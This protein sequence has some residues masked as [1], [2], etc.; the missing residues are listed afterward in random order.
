MLIRRTAIWLLTLG[1]LVSTAGRAVAQP[2]H[3]GVYYPTPTP[4]W[5]NGSAPFAEDG[6][7][8]GHPMIEPFKPVGFEPRFDWFAPA[9]TSSYGRGQKG[10]IGIFLSYERLYWSFA[11]PEKAFIGS[12][13]ASLDPFFDNSFFPNGPSVDNRFIGSH[14]GWG[15]RWELGYTDTDDY[16][17]LVSVLDH[18]SQGSFRVDQNP[19]ISFLDPNSITEGFVTFPISDTDPQEFVTLGVGPTPAIAADLQMKNLVQL[20]GVELTRFY[21]ARRLHKGGYFELLYGVR[22][23]QLNDTFMAMAT[24]NGN[25]GE[26]ISFNG[27]LGLDSATATFSR[28]IFDGSTW[29][30]RANNNLVG[31]QIGV[32]FFRP[33]QRFTTSLSA[34][35]LAAANFQN[36]QL[37]TVLGTDTAAN[38]GNINV[39][40]ATSFRGLGSDIQEYTTTFAPM[41]ELRVDVAYNV[42]RAVGIKVGYTGLVVG[43]VSR[44]SNS[45]DY[46]AVNLIGIK[47]N[48]DQIFFSNGLNFGVE[49]NR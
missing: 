12:E 1:A 33:R 4:S 28:N 40:Y 45:I 19:A 46:D 26:T 38:Q 48:D 6:S 35:F 42:T 47:R 8:A 14:G 37:K 11:A 3:S 41:G 22:W 16:G 34:R 44:A 32:R 21:R 7:G 13:N 30:L 5:E 18:V 39:N 2:A 23:F 29:S 17:W 43:N 31:P 27:G 20:N 49:I 9:E 36:L 15:N 10:N 25:A 24:G